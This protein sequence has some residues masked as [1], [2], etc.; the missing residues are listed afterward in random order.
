MDNQKIY[1]ESNF[2]FDN[3]N[4]TFYF[5]TLLWRQTPIQYRNH[6]RHD[7]AWFEFH[8]IRNG[9]MN[10][11]T[12]TTT[13]QLQSGDALLIPPKI[14]HATDTLIDYTEFSNFGFE[15][16]QTTKKGTSEDLFSQFCNALSITDCIP[17]QGN[18]KLA[19]FISDLCELVHSG[20]DV[21]S[22]RMNT[23]MT[24]FLFTLLDIL[25][26]QDTQLKPQS[27]SRINSRYS[28]LDFMSLN[29]AINS[30][31]GDTSEKTYLNKKQINRIC[32]QRYDTT[33]KQRQI[34]VRI[35]NA[36]K[37]LT[38]TN[39]T[40]DEIAATI[41]YTNLTSFYKAFRNSVGVT[42]AKYRKQF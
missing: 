29:D 5:G 20:V 1:L 39:L 2:S 24:S 4:V 16:K 21:N 27:Q 34:R 25:V 38:D 30:S 8:F 15:F 10:I 13:H 23:T 19:H 18:A 12:D 37:L 31:L 28:W 17:I 3:I 33:Y 42:P 40:V 11:S 9:A 6:G 14:F 36:K 35:E 32:K 22:C 41:G 7:H 26:G